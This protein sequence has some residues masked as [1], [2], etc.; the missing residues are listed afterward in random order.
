VIASGYREDALR[1]RFDRISFLRKPYM[2]EQLRAA[3]AS[4][5]VAGE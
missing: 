1:Q 2:A 4:L 3:L 5:N